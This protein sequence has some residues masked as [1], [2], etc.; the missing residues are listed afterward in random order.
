M[1]ERKVDVFERNGHELVSL[2]L[3]LDSS[4]KP[5]GVEGRKERSPVCRARH[6]TIVALEALILAL[7]VLLKS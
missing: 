2:A 3:Q 6:D 5:E 4:A 1:K 7:A